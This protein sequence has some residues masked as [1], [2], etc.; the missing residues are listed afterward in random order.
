MTR[1]LQSFK[2]RIGAGMLVLIA[3][4]AALAGWSVREGLRLSDT[5]DQELNL[6]QESTTVGNGLVRSVMNEIR[7]AEQYFV[8]PTSATRRRFIQSGDSAYVYQSRFTALRGLPTEDRLRVNRIATLQAGIEVRYAL[9][10]ALADIGA[11]GEALD[12]AETAR[13]I[14][15]SL[16]AEL[17][18]L[19][20]ARSQ[21]A[22]ARSAVLR[23]DTR[24]RMM[25]LGGVFVAVLAL[26]LVL[27]NHMVRSVD[28]DLRSMAAAA[29]RFGAGDLRPV[30][31]GSMP[32]ELEPLAASLDRMS[33]RLRDLVASVTS[34]AN[35]ISTSAG[36]F[37]AMS[38]ELAASSGEIST[39]MVKVSGSAETQVRGMEAA[40]SALGRIRDT[41]HENA[42]E[43]NRLDHLGDNVA[44]LSQRHYRDVT[45]ASETLL[46]V[47]QF[48]QESALQVEGLTRLS[49]S[50]TEFID[51]IKQ[52]SSQT[53]LLALNAAIEA[54][55]AGEHG[56]GFAVVA[57]E[58]RNLADSS[59]K[60]AEEVT[61]TV[62]TIRDKVREVAD[63]MRVG[64]EKVRGIEGVAKAAAGALDSISHSVGEIREAAKRVNESAGVNR[65]VVDELAQ[66]TTEVAAAASQHASASQEVSAAAEEQSASTEQMA[67]AAGELLQGAQRLT[68]LVSQFKT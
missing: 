48:V 18:Q 20:T 9:A 25:M 68:E 15:D 21:S 5:V 45:A 66:R 13:P 17:Q 19:V 41:T 59:A 56:R 37:S 52:I 42:E 35:Q 46:D 33:S 3:L 12:R 40:D 64:T 60:A 55:R 54:A 24:S 63:T 57:D 50:I 58:V 6:L 29:E 28:S 49:E 31:L 61:Q 2:F 67:A 32:M 11:T 22:S 51:L 65:K 39:A 34:E 27:A 38:E 10:H 14:T 47:R 30:N 4:V 23:Q 44:D 8:A 36:D 1:L 16:V 7:A 53:N 62:S 43:A 26:G